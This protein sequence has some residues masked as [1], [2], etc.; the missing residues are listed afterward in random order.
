MFP[1]RDNIPSARYPV[2][3]VLLIGVNLAVFFWELSLGRQLNDVLLHLGLVPIR[4]TSLEVAAHFHPV[5]QVV[6][7]FTSMFLHGGWLHVLGN[8]WTLWI[9][10]DNVEDRLGHGRYLLLYLASGLAAGLLHI[11]TFGFGLVTSSFW[12]RRRRR[13]RGYDGVE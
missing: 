6:P 4:Y 12:N 2:V 13:N 7:F 1:L 10:G 11:L 8:L 9:F 3:T 5:A